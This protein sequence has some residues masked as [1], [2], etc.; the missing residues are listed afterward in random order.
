MHSTAGVAFR[1]TVPEEFAMELCIATQVEGEGAVL[2]RD[3][4]TLSPQY[5]LMAA[6]MAT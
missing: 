2:V 3:L 1:Q 4:E 5:E 6:A